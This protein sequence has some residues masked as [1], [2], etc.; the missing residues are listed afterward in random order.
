MIIDIIFLI[1]LL[2]AVIKGFSRGFIVA[3]FSFFAIIIGVAAAMKLSYIVANWL[4]QSFNI[5]G[6]WLPILSFIIV[7]LGVILLVRWIANIIQAAINV[8]ML[9]WLNKLG[10]IILYLFVYLFVYSIFLFYL[11]KM[12]FIHAETIKKSHAYFLIEPFGEKAIDITG[13]LMPVFKNIFQ[14][15]SG[16]FENIATNHT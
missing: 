7:L 3:I 2:L 8:A 14:Q 9:G 4:Q 12:N 1:L 11:T 6:K 5:N 15:L 13:K 10:G 16:F